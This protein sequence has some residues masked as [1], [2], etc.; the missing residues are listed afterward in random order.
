[1]QQTKEAQNTKTQG[2]KGNWANTR[3]FLCIKKLKILKK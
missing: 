2:K 3:Q 1:M